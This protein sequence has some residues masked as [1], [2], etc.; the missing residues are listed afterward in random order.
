MTKPTLLFVHG[1]W[2]GAWC[3]ESVATRLTE[4]GW[5]VVA[6]DLPSVHAENKAELGMYDDAAAVTSA[7]EAID[8]PVVV[9]AHSYGGVPTTQGADLP[10]VQH[11]VYIASF[12]LDIGQSLLAAVGGEHPDW[13]N[14]DG[15]LVT[16]GNEALPPSAIFFHDVPEDVAADATGKLK[17]MS[18]QTVSDPLTTVAWKGRQTTFVVTLQDAAF[19]AVAQHA[20]ASAIGATAIEVDTSH[21]PFMSQPERVVEIVE[22][23]ASA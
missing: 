9:V 6:I 15:K 3:W 16:P 1:A 23:A 2:H 18:T 14:I 5:D 10:N 7:I 11:I 13:W 22:Q 20:L 17:S 21:S 8:G 12:A 19:P 4:R